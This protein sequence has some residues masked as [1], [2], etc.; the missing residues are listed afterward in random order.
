MF[1]AATTALAKIKTDVLAI[2]DPIKTAT[3]NYNT[4]TIAIDVLK[5]DRNLANEE[6]TRY[7]NLMN[8]LNN[9]ITNYASQ[10]NILEDDIKFYEQQKKQLEE[11]LKIFKANPTVSGGAYKAIL[12]ADIKKH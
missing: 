4:K 5:T 11:A 12:A 2:S 8:N 7:E 3:T 6:K 10:I 9:G 1:N